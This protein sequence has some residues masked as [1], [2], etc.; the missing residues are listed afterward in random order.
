MKYIQTKALEWLEIYGIRIDKERD[1][2]YN[3]LAAEIHENLGNREIAMVSYN[4]LLEV[5]AINNSYYANRISML[6]E[7]NE[8]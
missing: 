7:G 2:F 6:W 5:D 1:I 4:I 8:Q 3:R